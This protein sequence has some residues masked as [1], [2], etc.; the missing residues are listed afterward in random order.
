MERERVLAAAREKYRNK[1]DIIWGGCKLSFF[2]DTTK[3]TAQ[4]RRK[5]N[6]RHFS[7]LHP[8][9]EQEFPKGTELRKNKLVALKSQA[10][11]QVQF[12]QKFMKH[13]ETVTL[14]SYQLAWNIARAKKPYNEGD[15]IKKCLIDAFEILAPGDDKLKRSVSDVQLS[16]HSVKRRISDINTAVESQLHSDLQACE[17]FSVALD[18]SCDIQDKPQLAI[19]ARSVS[20]E[21]MIKEELLD[22]VTLK[23]RTRGIDVKEAM[24]AAFAKANL[25]IPKLTA[26]ATDGAPAMIGSVNGLVGLCKADQTFPDFW[27]FHCIIHREQLV[28]KSLNLNNAMKPVMEIVNY[29]R[30]HALNHRQFRNLIAELDQGLPGDLP[31]HCTVR[32]LS[33]SKVFSRFFELL[34]AVKLF[35]EEK[36]KDYP[37]LSDLEWIMDLAFS[38]DMLCHLD[39]LNLTLQASEQ[40]TSAALKKKRDRYATLVANLHESFVTR[41]C[42]LQLKRPQITFLVNPFNAET[43]CLKAPLVTDEAA[44]ELE[45]IDLCEEDQLKAVLRE[46]TV[47]FW[48]SVPIEKYPNIKRAALKI[49]SMFGSTY[50]CESVFSTLKHVKSKHRSVLSDTHL[51][52]L[53]RVATTEYKPDL[54]R[55]VQDKECQKSH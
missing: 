51:K 40:V 53:L 37:E 13:S 22:I 46:G 2:P 28:S 43:D 11:K 32:W 26:I 41:F 55:I 31:L 3:E 21:C 52:E 9:I 44:A 48:K 8:N 36:D 50:V 38:V 17:Y 27:N 30:T 4:K 19:F 35:M 29:I 54:K 47:E 7:S 24:M 45:M 23:D 34:D 42:D 25:P 49:L 10:E 39:R 14:A 1:K 18:E 16:R 33:K 15:F 12:F 6:E 20:N 5:F